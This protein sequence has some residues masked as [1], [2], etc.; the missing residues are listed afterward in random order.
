MEG[1][2]HM[3]DIGQEPEATPTEGEEP[4]AEAAET[5][6]ALRIGLPETGSTFST[7]PEGST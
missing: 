4:T 3:S 2:E 6:E 1:G 5:A 7:A